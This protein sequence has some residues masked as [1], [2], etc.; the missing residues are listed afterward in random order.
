MKEFI[1]LMLFLIIL[2]ASV[3]YCNLHAKNPRNVLFKQEKELCGI[4]AI[5]SNTGCNICFSAAFNQELEVPY[6]LSDI[7]GVTYT[8]SST[9]WTHNFRIDEPFD[10]NATVKLIWKKLKKHICNE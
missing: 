1:L 5:V 4:K 2:A 9:R 6:Y 7:P 3:K 10:A 8:Y